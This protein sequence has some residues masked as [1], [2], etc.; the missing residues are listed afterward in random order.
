M[1]SENEVGLA[2]GGRSLT[3]LLGLLPWGKGGVWFQRTGSPQD[4]RPGHKE[5]EQAG[6]GMGGVGRESFS[7]HN[8]SL[9]VGPDPLGPSVWLPQDRQCQRRLSLPLFRM[10]GTLSAPLGK[11]EAWGGEFCFNPESFC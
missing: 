10:S 9:S 2:W 5:D 11:S 8:I 7:A 3:G 1:K 4:Y 6:A